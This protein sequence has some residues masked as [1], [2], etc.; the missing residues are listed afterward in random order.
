[1]AV[2]HFLKATCIYIIGIIII[3]YGLIMFLTSPPSSMM[4]TSFYLMYIGLAVS[5]IGGVYG[6]RRLKGPYARKA[7]PRRWPWQR[8]CGNEAPSKKAEHA[9]RKVEQEKNVKVVK[10]LICPSCGEENKYNAVFC[11]RCGRKIRK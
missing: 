3:A 1:M 4:S 8:K 9:E 5:I 6:K 11:D 7:G 2:V 10:I